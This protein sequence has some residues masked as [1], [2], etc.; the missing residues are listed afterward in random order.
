MSTWVGHHLL[1][2]TAAVFVLI[3]ALLAMATRRAWLFLLPAPALLALLAWDVW[4]FSAEALSYAVF[5]GVAGYVGIGVG[6]V[7]RSRA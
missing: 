5:I 4:E 3:G 7:L 1:E 2:A 6:G